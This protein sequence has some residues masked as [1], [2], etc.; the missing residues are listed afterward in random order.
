MPNTNP[1]KVNMAD[2]DL[3]PQLA[4]NG[5]KAK[6]PRRGWFCA[7][8]STIAAYVDGALGEGKNRFESHLAKCE[9]CRS[10]VADAVRDQ[11]ETD[12]AAPPFEVARKAMRLVSS[13][14]SGARWI[15][16]PVGA[17]A[18]VAVVVAGVLL[19]KPASMHVPS[20]PVSSAPLIAK[21]NPTVVPGFP[22]RETVRQS[23]VPELLPSILVPQVGD[24]V[25]RKQL[26][27][28]WKPLANA[29]SYEVQVVTS[30]GD[31]VWQGETDQSSLQVPEDASLKEHTYFVWV[32]ADFGEGRMTRSAPVAFRVKR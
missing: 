5:T 27:F 22:P 29:R 18:V 24:L 4:G 14:P 19:L 3:T 16:A 2:E 9:H 21:T 23:R 25:S 1:P 13:R 6:V 11:R 28:S 8:D 20:P 26:T 32:T 7:G 17:A 15:W 31:V 30:A 10:A 12:L